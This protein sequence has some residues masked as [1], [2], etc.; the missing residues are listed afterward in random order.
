MSA[1][2]TV[3]VSDL[4]EIGN[5]MLRSESGHQT[6]EFRK[7]VAAMMEALLHKAEQYG[8]FNY[9]HWCSVGYNAWERDGRP[10]GEAKEKYF[11]DQTRRTYYMRGRVTD[12]PIEKRFPRSFPT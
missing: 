5:K 4:L 2:K 1:R 11:G 10:E 6:P 9:N 7:G 12:D 8:G 3:D